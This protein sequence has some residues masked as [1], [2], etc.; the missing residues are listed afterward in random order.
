MKG[1][2]NLFVDCCDTPCDVSNVCR[3]YYSECTIY[4]IVSV[5]RSGLDDDDDD[6]DD[7]NNN[8]NNK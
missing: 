1:G 7:N 6:D 5:F 8:N 4:R 2:V 3:R